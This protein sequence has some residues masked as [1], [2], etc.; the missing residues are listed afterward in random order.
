MKLLIALYIV[1][2][3][4]CNAVPS[5]T[6]STPLITASNKHIDAD[7]PGKHKWIAVSRDLEKLGFIFG[8]EVCVENAGKMNGV[9]VVEDRMN[10]RFTN[11][12]D[13]LVDN[14]I[15]LGKWKEVIITLNSKRKGNG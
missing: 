3:T 11:K 9:W 4:V 5:Q 10:K 2:A 8:V 14:K 12:I 15:V 6:D 1:V 13:F 7:N